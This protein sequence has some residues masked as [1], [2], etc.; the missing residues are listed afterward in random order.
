[1]SAGILNPGLL[2]ILFSLLGS[3]KDHG[4]I[5]NKG[6][7]T[8]DNRVIIGN[9]QRTDYWGGYKG[10][11]GN[12]EWIH[13]YKTYTAITRNDAGNY[14]PCRTE[15]LDLL[16][17]NM[18]RYGYPA[19]VHSYGLWY[20]RRRD[21]HDESQRNSPPAGPQSGRPSAP[22]PYRFAKGE[23]GYL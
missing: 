2:F 12:P 14:G 21:C 7:I 23:S 3:S 6:W 15:E 11:Q 17:E 22:D 13:N 16:T 8:Y 1:M 19:F 9:G 4:L 18:I 5:I 10:C 20:D